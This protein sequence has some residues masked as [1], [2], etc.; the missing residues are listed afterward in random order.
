MVVGEASHQYP[1]VSVF[2]SSQQRL[3][4]V[5]TGVSEASAKGFTAISVDNRQVP[6]LKAIA[7]LVPFS[8]LKIKK[9]RHRTEEHAL[10]LVAAQCKNTTDGVS[11]PTCSR[12]SIY[13]GCQ[14]AYPHVFLF[15]MHPVH[16]IRPLYTYDN[17][18]IVYV[19]YRRHQISP[20]YVG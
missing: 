4:F 1:T 14:Q 15:Q 17:T 12:Q 13:E 16:D 3:P 11:F 2:L 10:T 20:F 7:F 8:L 5:G 19:C 9:Q 6:A 18:Y